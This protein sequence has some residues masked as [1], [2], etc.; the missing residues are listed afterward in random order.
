MASVLA[1]LLAA[2]RGSVVPSS[3]GRDAA[4][5]E[6]QVRV[7]PRQGANAPAEAPADRNT[8]IAGIRV[9]RLREIAAFYADGANEAVV[10]IGD[11]AFVPHDRFHTAAEQIVR[12]AGERASAL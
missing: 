2:L 12:A 6:P 3:G 4:R 7:R 11:C 9:K 5:Y 8:R 1:R 10:T